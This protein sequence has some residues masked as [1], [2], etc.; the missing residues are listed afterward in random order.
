MKYDIDI[1][2]STQN[3]PYEKHSGYIIDE[4]NLFCVA[5][6]T[7]EYEFEVRKQ[8]GKVTVSRKGEQSYSITLS[9]TPSTFFLKTPF[10]SLSYTTKLKN[11]V[12]ERKPN[13][14]SVTL[15]YTLSDSSGHSQ[16]NILKMKGRI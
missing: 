11:F 8:N 13:S 16:E 3:E 7:D 15:E 14:Y 12:V 6:S 1:H 5:F 9:S 4:P 2:Y 10:G